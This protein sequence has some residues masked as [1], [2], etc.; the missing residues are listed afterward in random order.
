ME[1]CI[2]CDRHAL[3][4]LAE[5]ELAFA[6]RDK[7]PVRQLHTLVLPKRHVAD[8]FNLRPEELQAIFELARVVRDSIQAEDASVGG[9]NFGLNNGVV[10]GQ[11]IMH[12]HFHLIPRRA[13]EEPPPP[14]KAA[15]A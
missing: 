10:A 1:N 5:N 6:V 14:A 9:F 3:N 13:G 12:V 8:G 7:Y 11:R 2:F 15:T 4:V